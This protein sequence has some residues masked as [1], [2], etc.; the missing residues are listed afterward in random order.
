M[1]EVWVFL[2]QEYGQKMEV[3]S[4]IV[5]SLCTF[6]FSA[7]AKTDG[8]K[9][10]ELFCRWQQVVED[11]REIGKLKVLDHEPTLAKVGQKF[12]STATRLNYA[13]LR[14][15]LLKQDRTE[16]EIM[17]Q[18]MLEERELYKAMDRLEDQRSSVDRGN[19]QSCFNCNKPGHQKKCA[20]T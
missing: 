4:E 14:M 17:S 8:M 13:K 2:D 7:A 10:T 5:E 20:L 16:L 18:F 6:T 11:L 12:P 1:E 19:K 9:F 3:T 15:E